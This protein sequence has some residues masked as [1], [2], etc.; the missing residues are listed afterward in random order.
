MGRPTLNKIGAII[1]I[2]C[3][4]KK[5]FTNDGEIATVR[6]NQVV[7]RKCYNA[8]LEVA[9]KK[10][11]KKEEIRPPSSSKVMLIDLDVWGR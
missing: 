1:S 11:T 9:K 6:A 4:T 5:F 3:L 2:A 8:C 10:K 7:A